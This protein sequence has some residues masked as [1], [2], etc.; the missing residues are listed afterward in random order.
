MEDQVQTAT[1]AP[2]ATGPAT[3]HPAEPPPEAPPEAPPAAASRGPQEFPVTEGDRLRH[4]FETGKY[5]YARAL[6]RA[7]Y[8]AE[9]LRLQAELLKVQIWTQETGQI[10]EH[11]TP[12]HA[13]VCALTKPSDVEKGRWFFQRSIAHLP[14]AGEMVFYDRS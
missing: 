9:K 2:P 11:L 6:G 12:R 3:G 13:R 5:P 4:A 10:M 7:T 8:E 1:P 14:T